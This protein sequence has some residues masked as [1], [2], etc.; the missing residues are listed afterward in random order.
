MSTPSQRHCSASDGSGSP[1][2]SPGS[3]PTSV[4]IRPVPAS[5]GAASQNGQN[6]RP[7]TSTLASGEAGDQGPSAAKA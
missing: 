5:A 2:Q 4:P 1:T 3:T 6:G 7:V